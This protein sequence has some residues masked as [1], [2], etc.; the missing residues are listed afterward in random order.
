MRYATLLQRQNRISEAIEQFSAAA[1]IFHEHHRDIE[2]LA[3]C[4]SIALLDPENPARHATLGE[5]GG[6]AAA[7]GPGGAKFSF[8]PAS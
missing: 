1:D 5:F 6:R 3:C 4:E 8:A 2:A 7:C